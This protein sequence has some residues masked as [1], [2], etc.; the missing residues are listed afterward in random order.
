MKALLLTLLLAVGALSAS[1]RVFPPEL[2][3]REVTPVG[4]V[5]AKVAVPRAVEEVKSAPE[6]AV[7]F[8]ELAGMASAARL[9]WNAEEPDAPVAKDPL[10]WR[11][12]AATPPVEVFGAEVNARSM[13]DVASLMVLV[14]KPLSVPPMTL[15]YASPLILT[16]LGQWRDRLIR[17]GR[18]NGW[19]AIA[20]DLEAYGREMEEQ[21]SRH[22][23]LLRP[24]R[25]RAAP[26]Q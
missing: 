7:Q 26:P 1:A 24:H 10:L 2:R 8:P 22:E 14:G 11:M 13:R 5:A 3:A 4:H 15:S 25:P 23:R 6:W 9:E 18:A 21:L 20:A 19:D 16:D 12:G 17:D